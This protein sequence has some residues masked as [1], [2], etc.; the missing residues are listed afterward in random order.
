VAIRPE[1][2]STP[3]FGRGRGEMGQD[4]SSFQASGGWKRELE[5]LVILEG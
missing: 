1:V 3:G 2:D 4:G 5:A